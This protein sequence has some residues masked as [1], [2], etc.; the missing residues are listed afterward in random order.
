MVEVIPRIRLL[1]MSTVVFHNVQLLKANYA[2]INNSTNN[3]LDADVLLFAEARVSVEERDG[4]ALS[5]FDYAYHSPERQRYIHS[6][7]SVVYVV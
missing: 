6:R 7:C 5:G 2:Y 1:K 4:F 3:L